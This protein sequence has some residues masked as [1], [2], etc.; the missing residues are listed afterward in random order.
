MAAWGTAYP[1]LRAVYA[2]KASLKNNMA[3]R[4]A[5]RAEYDLGR[6]WA[7]QAGDRQEQC[8]RDTRRAHEG[9][10]GWEKDPVRVWRCQIQ[11]SLTLG[12]SAHVFPRVLLQKGMLRLS[13]HIREV[14]M[15]TMNRSPASAL[16]LFVFCL[17]CHS[18]GYGVRACRSCRGRVQDLVDMPVL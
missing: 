13:M 9:G 3:R 1:A 11:H 5:F 2:S 14:A 17:P 7:S 6:D 18:I 10:P 8:T 12:I 16:T 4:K 15:S